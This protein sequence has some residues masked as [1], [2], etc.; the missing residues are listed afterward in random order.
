MKV[1]N[2]I[3]IVLVL[4]VVFASYQLVVQIFPA[5]ANIVPKAITSVSQNSLRPV[6]DIKVALYV[7][8]W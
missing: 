6:K 2:A 8:D 4:A 5:T 1:V 7:T 3:I